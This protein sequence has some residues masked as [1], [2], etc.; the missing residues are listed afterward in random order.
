MEMDRHPDHLR[1]YWDRLVYPKLLIF[2]E[3]NEIFEDHSYLQKIMLEKTIEE[4]KIFK[5]LSLPKLTEKIRYVSANELGNYL[6]KLNRTKGDLSF[7]EKLEEELFKVKANLKVAKVATKKV[8][9]I[10]QLIG[11]YEKIR[12]KCAIVTDVNKSESTKSQFL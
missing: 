1:K 12:E 8:Q 6:R 4:E 11:V 10:V 2:E 7:Q 3:L 9:E 5:K